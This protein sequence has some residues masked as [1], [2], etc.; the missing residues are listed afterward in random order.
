MAVVTTDEFAAY[1]GGWKYTGIQEQTAQQI[2][3]GTQSELERHL[4]RPLQM[5]RVLELAQP[6][7]DGRHYFAVTPIVGVHGIY[8]VHPDTGLKGE[9][10]TELS[11]LRWQRGSNFLFYGGYGSQYY[12]DYTGGINADVNPGV[13]LAIMRVAA[14]E[15]GYK[16]DETVTVSNTEG[17]PPEDG[18]SP[19]PKGWTADEVKAFDR[20]RRRVVL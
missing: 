8:R 14:R 11:S 13:K 15:F 6:D 2:L 4:N 17:R 10:V 1:M 18:P 16:F 20:L 7:M 5:R 3:D 9:A 12:V 19:Q